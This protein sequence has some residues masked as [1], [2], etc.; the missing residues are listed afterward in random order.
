[1]VVINLLPYEHKSEIRAARTNVV[2]LRY[3][4]I[5]ITAAIVLGVLIGGAYVALNDSKATAQVKADENTARLSEY[6]Q[7]RAR[8]DAYRSDLATAKTILDSNVSFSKLIYQIAN[9]VPRGVVL[10]DLALDPA[11]F[12]SSVTMNASAKTFNDAS[13]LRDAFSAN[14]QVFS[15]V[16]VQTIRSSETGSSGNPYPVKVVLSVVI[17]KGAIQ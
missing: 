6:Q 12:G 17:N 11:S 8:A 9:T 4:M 3:I 14:G 10:D 16:Q 2:L 15:N 1:M 13:K 7:T 5:L